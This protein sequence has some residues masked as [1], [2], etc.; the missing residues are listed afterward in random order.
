MSKQKIYKVQTPLFCSAGSGSALVYTEDRKN[1][2]MMPITQD[3]IDFMNGRA[4]VFVYGKEY[5]NQFKIEKEAPWQE[6]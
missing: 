2:I 6:W 3:L 4:K 1:Q 5:L